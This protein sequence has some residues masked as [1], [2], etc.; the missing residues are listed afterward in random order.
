MVRKGAHQTILE[1]LYESGK[2]SLPHFRAGKNLRSIY[3]LF[4]KKM[5]GPRPLRSS[6]CHVDFEGMSSNSHCDMGICHETLWKCLYALFQRCIHDVVLLQKVVGAIVRDE[7]FQTE[8]ERLL[9]ES[10]QRI[11]EETRKGVRK[12]KKLC[13][14]N[15]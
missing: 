4:R 11:L 10:I 8:R 13:L 5:E 1:M 3:Y 6:L 15:A 2:I 9:T 12:Y 7:P 14:K